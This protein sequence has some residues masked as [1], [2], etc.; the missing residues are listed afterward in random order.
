M[1]PLTMY[2][3][4]VHLMLDTELEV[5]TYIVTIQKMI[6]INSRFIFN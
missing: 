1:I 6:E 3:C 2:V 5:A 4:I